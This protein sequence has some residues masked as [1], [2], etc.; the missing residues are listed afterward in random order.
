MAVTPSPTEPSTTQR[1]GAA[2]PAS[3]ANGRRQTHEPAVRARDP[4]CGHERR[5]LQPDD[6]HAGEVGVGRRLLHHEG[7]HHEHEDDP[8]AV[9]HASPVRSL[10]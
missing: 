10:R 7:Q 5:G 9:A 6:N 4:D 8:V 1:T 3:A 2:M